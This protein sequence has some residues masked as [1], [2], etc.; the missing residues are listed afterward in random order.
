MA[1]GRR[2]QNLMISIVVT[3]YNVERY[4]AKCLDSIIGQSFK[5]IEIIVVDDGSTDKT[6][7]I[8]NEYASRF[9]N[10]RILHTDNNGIL[11]ARLNGVR[12]AVGDWIMFVDGDDLLPAYSLEIL[13]L[14]NKEQFDIVGGNIALEGNVVISYPRPVLNS[15]EEYLVSLLDSNTYPGCCAKLIRKDLFIGFNDFD[16]SIT[17]NE[18]L[19]M[20]SLLAEKAE[21]IFI[22]NQLPVYYYLSRPGSE[23]K[24][25]AQPICSWLSLFRELKKVVATFNS[26]SLNIA[27]STYVINRLFHFCIQRGN[28]INVDD[29]K[30]MQILDLIDPESLSNAS[31][32]KLKCINNLFRQHIARLQ[33]LFLN[34]IKSIGRVVIYNMLKLGKDQVLGKLY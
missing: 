15:R 5:D 13:N 30:I 16:K 23:S 3:A 21:S 18:D 19:L 24:R 11:L 33:Y 7:D 10:V 25:T 2:A 29:L 20:M 31:R 27:Y 26:N 28:F 4:I 22:Q 34:S 17:Q 1:F 14:L 9:D 12:D 8:C 32:K 6:Y